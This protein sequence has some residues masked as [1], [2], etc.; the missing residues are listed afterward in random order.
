MAWPVLM[1]DSGTTSGLK[2]RPGLKM[3]AVL[4]ISKCFRKVDLDIRYGEIVTNCPRK[5]TFDVD[6][7]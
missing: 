7:H 6:C 1:L 2:D 5:I 3:A 4:K